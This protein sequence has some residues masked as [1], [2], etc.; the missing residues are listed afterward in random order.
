MSLIQQVYRGYEFTGDLEPLYDATQLEQY[1]P[2]GRGQGHEWRWSRAYCEKMI[3]MCTVFEVAE[4]M[5]VEPDKHDWLWAV[6]KTT[7]LSRYQRARVSWE[8]H[9]G[10]A[11]WTERLSRFTD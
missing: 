6:Q 11:E 3:E 7:R 5:S 1:E 2:R 10:I 8:F 9:L 4:R